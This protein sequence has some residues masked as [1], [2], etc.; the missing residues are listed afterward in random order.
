MAEETTAVALA[1][2]SE[3]AAPVAAPAQPPAPAEQPQ[4][5]DWEAA[6]RRSAVAR[7]RAVA[8]T[9]A[10][11]GAGHEGSEAAPVPTGTEAP[12]DATPASPETAAAEPAAPAEPKLDELGRLHQPGTGQYLPVPPPAEPQAAAVPLRV[13]LPEGHPLRAQ[14]RDYITVADPAELDAVRALVNSTGVRRREAEDN[15]RRAQELQAELVRE[16]EQRMRLEAQTAAEGRWRA[17]PEYQQAVERYEELRE[18]MGDAVAQDYWR[19]VST[20]LEALEQEEF[21]SRAQ[22]LES[23]EADL[24]ADEWTRDAWD[25]QWEVMPEALRALPEYR[26]AFDAQVQLLNRELEADALPRF[27]E[28]ALANLTADERATRLT[29]LYQ[30]FARGFAERLLK[31]PRAQQVLGELTQARERA[32]KTQAEAKTRVEAQAAEARQKLAEQ[33]AVERFKREQ[34]AKRQQLPLNPLAGQ[35]AAPGTAPAPV[36]TPGGVEEDGRLRRLGPRELER[37]LAARA[38]E[39]A[40]SLFGR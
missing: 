28:R 26:E 12:D 37:S 22:E 30:D 34:A 25:K 6:A 10:S 20:K 23:Y 18:S 39:R 35:G 11:S 32:A 2:G 27:T 19:G 16:R 7:A 38:R 14:G 9:L 33:E 21:Q 1:E 15:K 17:T 31:Q 3:P 13:P 8:K 24:A 5:G 40:R 36:G 29:E 4:R